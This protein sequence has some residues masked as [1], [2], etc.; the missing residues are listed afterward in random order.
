MARW[1]FEPGHTDEDLRRAGEEAAVWDSRE[2]P[3]EARA[4]T[5]AT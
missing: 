4:G 5:P 3:S 1:I 2:L